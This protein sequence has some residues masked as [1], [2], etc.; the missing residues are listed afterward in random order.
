MAVRLC[1]EPLSLSQ[2]VGGQSII[3]RQDARWGYL[4]FTRKDDNVS[5]NDSELREFRTSKGKP[6]EGVNVSELP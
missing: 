2:A 3:H 1:E 5:R 6:H 4:S